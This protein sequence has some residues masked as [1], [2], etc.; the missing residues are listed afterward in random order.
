MFYN[1][2]VGS[3]SSVY[4]INVQIVILNGFCVFSYCLITMSGEDWCQVSN[5]TVTLISPSGAINFKWNDWG[6]WIVL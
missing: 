4:E 1:Y 2:N 3:L 5:I 6:I